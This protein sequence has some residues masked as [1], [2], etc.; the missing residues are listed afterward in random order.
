MEMLVGLHG[1]DSSA[2]VAEEMLNDIDPTHS[3]RHVAP[4]GP[5]RLAG[6]SRAWFDPTAADSGSGSGRPSTTDTRSADA[7]SA[8]KPPAG[9]LPAAA[10]QI[11]E[12]LR[13]MSSDADITTAEISVIGWSQGA[14]AAMAALAVTG[15]PIVGRL[16][17]WAGFLVD[18]PGVAYQL[19]QL[20]STK[21]L[22]IHGTD[23]DVVPSFFAE[24]LFNSLVDSGVDAEFR[25]IPA[26]HRR[27]PESDA[28]VGNWLGFCGREGE[29]AP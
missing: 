16:V 12:L 17:I 11:S 2:N 21:V 18:S 8:A 23:D 9:S 26:G 4:N 1:Y 19:A 22:V 29:T 6:G 20:R 14:A 15:A 3:L 24:D 10:A 25:S 27:T 7:R 5:V 28:I 13:A